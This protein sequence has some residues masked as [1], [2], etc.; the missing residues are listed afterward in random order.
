MAKKKE[1]NRIFKFDLAKFFRTGEKESEDGAFIEGDT[2]Y[3]WEDTDEKHKLTIGV[4]RGKF[5]LINGDELRDD[6]AEE[7]R[8]ALQ[9]GG[10]EEITTSFICLENAGIELGEIKVVK[11]T[12]DLSKYSTRGKEGFKDFEKNVPQGATYTAHR[13][14]DENRI[15]EKS[16]HRAGSMLFRYK[17]NSYICGMDGD[18]YFVSKLKTHPKSIS[19]AFKSLKPRRVVAYEKKSGKQASRQGEWF[20]IPVLDM[21]ATKMKEDVALPLQEGVGNP[22]TVDRYEE[23]KGRHY[24]KGDITHD[25]HSTMR[26]GEVLHEALQS[27]ALNSWSVQGVD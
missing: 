23:S 17:D 21:E 20:F 11:L 6:E 26:L 27:T 14:G 16:Y 2:L 1:D 18:S 22:H 9:Y 4:K 8:D 5:I 3:V 15:Q 13:H 24:C 10:K 12:Q 7:L 25:E 19:A